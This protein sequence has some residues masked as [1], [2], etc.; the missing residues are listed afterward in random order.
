MNK[1]IRTFDDYLSDESRVTASEKEQILLEASL[2]TRLVEAREACGIT[3]RQLAR[4]SGVKQPAIARLESMRVTP[5]IETILK[6]L[7]PLGYTLEIV[8]LNRSVTREA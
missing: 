1:E 6:V 2:I 4:L 5:T 3:Q 8:P 7:H